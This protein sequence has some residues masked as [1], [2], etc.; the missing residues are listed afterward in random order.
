MAQK[1]IGDVRTPGEIT[2]AVIRTLDETYATALRDGDVE[3]IE[4][5]TQNTLENF[6]GHASSKP[7]T[8]ENMA[9]LFGRA[10]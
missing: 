4:R 6:V 1:T 8:R 2:E 5:I 10:A 3:T 7:A 9:E